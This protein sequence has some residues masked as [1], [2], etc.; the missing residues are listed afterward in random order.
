MKPTVRLSSAVLEFPYLARH[1]KTGVVFLVL[2]PSTAVA[3]MTYTDANF[4][5]AQGTLNN[6]IAID[7]LRPLSHN[8]SVVLTND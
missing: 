4:D 2:G 5:I 6:G 8:E 7:D 1:S 3:L